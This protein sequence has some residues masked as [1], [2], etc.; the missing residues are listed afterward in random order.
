MTEITNRVGERGGFGIKIEKFTIGGG[1]GRSFGTQ[2]Y[3]INLSLLEILS[4][5]VKVSMTP[6]SKRIWNILTGH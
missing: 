3:V 5:A 6:P 2:E 4:S 1:G